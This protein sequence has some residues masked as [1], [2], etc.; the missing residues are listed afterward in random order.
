MPEQPSLRGDGDS[1]VLHTIVALLDLSALPYANYGA[2]DTS[3]LAQT[4]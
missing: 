1:T 2:T 3:A 4:E